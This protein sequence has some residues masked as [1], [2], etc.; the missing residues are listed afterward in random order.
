MILNPFKY[1][2]FLQDTE[3]KI[4]EQNELTR[5]VLK[6]TRAMLNGEDEWFLETVKKENDIHLECICK[7][8]DSH[9]H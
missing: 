7:Q 4:D 9:G 2:R 5:G 8:V 6:E 1:F 3:R